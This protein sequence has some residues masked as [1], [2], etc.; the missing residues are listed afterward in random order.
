MDYLNDYLRSLFD[1][2]YVDIDD[3]YVD[4]ARDL[5]PET[6]TKPTTYV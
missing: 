6:P 5:T 2:D 4:V 1:I 3:F